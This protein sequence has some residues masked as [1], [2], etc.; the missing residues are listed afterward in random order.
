MKGVLGGMRRTLA[1][2]IRFKAVT[3]KYP[4]EKREL[5]ERSRGLIALLLE[6]ETSIFKCE[7]CLM[8]EKACPPRAI[9]ISYNF[10]NGF[11]KRPPIAPRASYY[12]IRMV[13]TAPY[14]DRRPLSPAVLTVPAEAERGLDLGRAY[15]DLPGAP[16]RP[17]PQTP[18]PYADTAAA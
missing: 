11:R 9:S 3:R 2:L 17:G 4:Y 18:A 6:P 5:P 16:R 13:Q 1:H 7:S 10:R 15:R 8:C 12:R 14:G